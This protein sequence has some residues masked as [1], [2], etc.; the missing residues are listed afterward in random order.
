MFDYVAAAL[1]EPS[2]EEFRLRHF[3]QKGDV[4][5]S[6]Q[7]L[8]YFTIPTIFDQV[9]ASS[10]FGARRHDIEAFNMAN[11]F[12]KRGIAATPMKYGIGWHGNKYTS[13]ISI[14]A[15]GTVSL[16]HAGCEI[17]QGIDVKCAQ[18][19]SFWLK[20]PLDKIKVSQVSTKTAP[21]TSGTGG[22]HTSENNSQAVKAACDIINNRLAG[23]DRAGKTWEE[24]I[25]EALGMDIN[26]QALGH[27]AGGPSPNGS[28]QYCSYGCGVNE[29]QVDMLTGEAIVLRSD[30][31]LDCGIS[32]NPAVDLGQAQGGFTMGLG[33]MLT[34]EFEFVVD[35]VDNKGRLI[36]DGTWE[37]KP[38]SVSDIPSEFNVSLL[39]DCPNPLGFMQSKASGEPP[40][41]MS[42]GVVSAI[43]NAIRPH[44][45]TES[46]TCSGEAGN[47]SISELNAPATPLRILEASGI[48]PTDFTLKGYM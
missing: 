13:M 17:G 31:L 22:S 20:C 1:K 16:S 25:T 38:P 14:Y 23:I 15:D 3:Y 47:V 18:V 26:L 41:L 33:Y 9:L 8:E 24:L 44:G 45:K 48:Q 10:D 34:E 36:T 5:P 35:D 27:F 40:L 32:L 19:A 11:V 4:T 30:I 7:R 29:V 28:N 12:V 42:I 6:G 39:K 2:L 37:Y 43:R 21:N 46:L